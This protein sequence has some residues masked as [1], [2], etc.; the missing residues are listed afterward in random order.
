MAP[1]TPVDVIT[2]DEIET[3]TGATAFDA[4]AKLRPRYL[5]KPPSSDGHDVSLI[6]YVNSVLV[7]GVS[8][9]RDV[10]LATVKRIEYFDGPHATSRWGPGHEQGALLVITERSG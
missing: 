4:V 2:R 8:A 3:I 10:P 5:L 9:L 1:P 6:V 7:G